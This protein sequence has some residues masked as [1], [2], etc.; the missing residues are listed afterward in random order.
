MK[1][2][3]QHIANAY[4]HPNFFI[5]WIIG[6]FVL[7]LGYWWNLFFII[8]KYFMIGLIII[9]ITDFVFLI[10]Y[11]KINAQRILPDK[12][13]NGDFN[14][15]K[16]NLTSSY[17]AIV[18]TKII[19][20]IPI[21]FQKRD[22][23]LNLKLSPGKNKEYI[24]SLRPVQ[25]GNYSFGNLNIYVYSPLKLASYRYQFDNKK[26]VKVYPSFLQMRKY[27]L[28]ALT[29][30]FG[31]GL[32]KIRKIGHTMEFEQIKVYHKGDDFRSIN[33]KA[34]AKHNKLMANQYKDEQ[35]QTVY[36]LID[37][38]RT[39]KLP[40]NGMTLLDY[41]INSTLSFSNIVMK[42]NDLAGLIT[43]EN[44]IQSFVKPGNKKSDLNRIFETLYSIDNQFNETD[45]E[46]L[47]KFVKSHIPKRSLLM[48]Y[49]NFEHISSLRR[50]I[51]YLRKLAKK[52]LVVLIIFENVELKKLINIQP[53]NNQTLYHKLIAEEFAYQK[54]LMIQELKL[55]KIHSIFTAPENLTVATINKYTELKAK[56]LI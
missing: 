39:M 36:S 4:L 45:F 50:Q 52:H 31:S 24:Y 11:G 29:N 51:P 16:I 7:F 14:P 23:E 17:P 3:Y 53:K 18:F 20:E 21:Q 42:K 38:G 6:I 37:L 15:I 25:R 35:S 1:N 9:T 34:S 40:F 30:K 47:F 26:T 13:S 22:F 44:Q 8:G 32:R 19:D 41:A 56:A 5:A 2:F 43:F 55:H 49:T 12:F 28:I 48:I 27:E 33:W 10:Y 46:R 54:K